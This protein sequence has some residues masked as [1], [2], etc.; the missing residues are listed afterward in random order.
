M[1]PS[2]LAPPRPANESERLAAL[3][4]CGI[5]DTAPQ[6]EFDFLVELAADICEAPF[7]WLSL[8]DERRQWVKARH[9]VNFS[10]LPRAMSF[11]AY[12]ILGEDALVVTDAT[13]DDRFAGAPLVTGEPHVRF[14]A[15]APLLTSD[16][17]ALGALCVADHEPRDLSASQRDVL[18]ALAHQAVTLAERG[19]QSLELE[20]LRQALSAGS[21]FSHVGGWE[22][23]LDGDEIEWSDETYRIFGLKKDDGAPASY[24]EFLLLIHPDDRDRVDRAVRDTMSSGAPMNYE[25][26]V[27]R[28]DGSAKVIRTFGHVIERDGKRT[29]M[30]GLSQD[31]T[32]ESEAEEARRQTNDKLLIQGELL[33]RIDVGVAAIDPDGTVTHWNSGAER[34]LGWGRHEAV[35]SSLGELE[36]VSLPA[37]FDPGQLLDGI[38]EQ[39]R[40]VGE[41]TLKARDGSGRPTQ[42]TCSSISDQEGNVTG[43]VAVAMDVTERRRADEALRSS[44]EGYRRILETT[45]EALY[46]V[47]GE[48]FITFVNSRAASLLGF[49]RSELIGRDLDDLVHEDDRAF[50]EEKAELRRRGLSDTYEL[51][52]KKKHGDEVW[53]MLSVSPVLGDSGQFLGALKMATDITE[54]KHA[55]LELKKRADQQAVLAELGRQALIGVSVDEL[56]TDATR[57]V[58]DTL[59]LEFARV[60][61]LDAD[62]NRLVFRYGVGELAGP[63]SDEAVPVGRGSHAGYTLEVGEPV[64]VTN[65]TR[66]TRF[67]PSLIHRKLGVMSGVTAII[68]GRDRP[69]GILAAH[70]TARREYTAEEVSFMQSVANVLGAAIAR[71]R[72]E[73]LETELHQAQKLEA[74]GQLAG[75]VAHD[76]NNLLSV[77]L[78]YGDMLAEAIED[79]ELR[80]DALE[81]KGAAERGARLTQQLL[82]FSRKDDAAPQV[83]EVN[84][85]IDE[86]ENLLR[87]TL[88]ESVELVK[89][90]DADAR[91]VRL[92]AGQLDQVL[93]N[94]TINARDAMPSGGEVKIE[95]ENIEIREGSLARLGLKPGLYVRLGVLDGGTGMSEEVAEHAFDPFFTTKPKGQGTGLGLATVYGIAKQAGGGAEILSEP[96]EGTRVDVYFPATRSAAPLVEVKPKQPKQAGGNETILLVEDEDPVRELAR[97][98]LERG[99]YQV[100]TAPDGYRARMLCDQHQGPIDLVLTDVVLPRL[101]GAKLADEMTTLRP[102]VRLLYMSGYAGDVIS[103]QGIADRGSALI[104][105]PFTADI[106]LGAVRE[107]LDAPEPSEA[108][109]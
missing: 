19:R 28:P 62:R 39:G 14:Y 23:T 12:T 17:S 75:G 92:G 98:I 7:A 22:W 104:Q 63:P 40:W 18:L 32:T 58:S 89:S 99:G 91:P 36:V 107:A 90:L 61:E 49:K 95:T 56:L 106:L 68:D 38:G 60:L 24:R 4:R 76:F 100:I 43:F 65:F 2:G 103:R 101:S 10:E 15:G 11:C 47:D 44:E 77:I 31:I 66:E 9:G 55:E 102:K 69:F 30:R 42:L 93:V 108:R 29:G 13:H 87:R 6:P 64:A 41:I 20:T 71:E 88:V 81:I 82:V 50:L 5:L 51:R 16:G 52:L 46:M 54:R 26:R 3:D 27:V 94:L 67:E 78:S 83:I 48:G 105:K 33:D 73:R 96:G 72:A 57:M 59:N 79:P 109:Q 34:L 74:V 97:R 84:G 1:E 45:N 53:V 35:G 25:A 8:V 85:T 80:S 37:P 86:T 70:S 21:L